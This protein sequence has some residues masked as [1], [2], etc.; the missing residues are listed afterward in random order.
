MLAAD[1]RLVLRGGHS[2]PAPAVVRC[3]GWPM[4]CAA[5]IATTMYVLAMNPALAQAVNP[6][7]PPPTE[8]E[9]TGVL[10]DVTVTATKEREPIRQ[11]AP[12][13]Y[14]IRTADMTDTLTGSNPLDLVKNLP[15][16][17]YTS[18][19]PYGLDLSD[20]TTFVRGFHQNELALVFEGIP[21][22]DSSYG[23]L[24]GTTP[25]NIGVPDDI[26]SVQVSPGTARESAFS[27]VVTGG[28]IRYSLEDPA[29][30][31]SILVSQTYGSSDTLV[32]T[33]STQTGQLGSDG[34]KILLG[35]QR[36]SDDKYQAGGTQYMLRGNFK[37][38][39]DVPWGDFTVFFSDSHAEIWGYDDLSF[40][41][42]QNLGW[43]ADYQYPNYQQAYLRALP[44]NANVSCGYY[45]C[46]EL[47]LL[48]PY[49]SGQSTTDEIGSIA[50]T[51]NLSSALSGKVMLYGATNYTHI[52]ITDPT[53]PSPDGAPFSEE[54]WH[55]HQTRLGVTA[56]LKYAVGKHV[57]TTGLWQERVRAAETQ[58]WYNEPSL[59]SGGPPLQVI[60]P[61]NLYG[62]A[63]Q[64]ENA[65]RFKTS[66]GQFYLHDDYSLTDRLTF[67]AGFKAI[68][69]D[70]TGGG[71]GPDPAPYGTLDA[72]NWFLP[73]VSA[74]WRPTDGTDVFADLAETETGYRISPRG[75]IGYSASLWTA[76]TQQ[77]FDSAASSI[78][79]EHDWNLTVG[80][81]HRFGDLSVSVDAYYSV[82]SDRLL[83]ATVN[84]LFQI[85][86]TVGAVDRSDIVGSDVGVAYRF[87]DYWR[88][89]ESAG[90]SKF[91]Y[92]DNLDVE[93][94][95]YPI[96]GAAQPGYPEYTLVSDLSFEYDS[97]EAGVN[98]TE[99][100]HQPFS[101]EN[102][103]YGY[104]YWLV[105]AHASY[106]IEGSGKRPDVKV[107]LDVHNLLNRQQVGTIGVCGFPF[108]G[109]FQTMNRSAPRQLFLKVSARY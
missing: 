19:D 20:A 53:T 78:K 18:T 36:I 71:I 43:T 35:F 16:V 11:V 63:F 55:P 2:S 51:F 94:V 8:N 93:G 38:E 57:I 50:H 67:G 101:Y 3:S 89:S 90:L 31:P 69:F 56:E 103:I 40:A 68:E 29:A 52:A 75:N 34:P 26:S 66:N 49:D 42:I 107:R 22:N 32:T 4:G 86:N 84:N 6:N 44:E 12:N 97:I 17:V 88:F 58:G 108:R 24:G 48:E 59:S 99:Y 64:T 62:P 91:T 27:S 109:D 72:K 81:S 85:V 60:G 7:T 5:A 46:G 10:E 21:L 45:T 92:G 82:I 95:V 100:F 14:E 73:H 83:S 106:D 30:A 9:D 96:R 47:S 105:I 98:S 102:D 80:T 61:Y 87:L 70:T 54:V 13:T 28:E 79:P 41:M 33:L 23:S 104:N 15:G 25:L 65:S 76:S 74:T 1:R 77:V 39:Q 37:A